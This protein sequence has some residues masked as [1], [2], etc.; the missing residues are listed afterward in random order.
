MRDRV[1]QALGTVTAN[2]GTVNVLFADV[3]RYAELV[4]VKGYEAGNAVLAAVGQRLSEALPGSCTASRWVRDKFVILAPDFDGHQDFDDL[5]AAVL[6]AF[7][8]PIDVDG[9]RLNGTVRIGG[10]QAP[11]DASDS[12]TLIELAQQAVER[13][14]TPRESG[15]AAHDSAVTEAVTA[16]FEIEGRLRDTLDHD[17]LELVYQPSSLFSP[18]ARSVLKL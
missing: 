7:A 8:T 15:F 10:A 17:A 12:G 4:R 6:N 1:D 16:R 13:V 14:T 3:L 5:V 2:G 11:K 18:G 9:A